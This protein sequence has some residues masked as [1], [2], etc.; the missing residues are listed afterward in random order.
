MSKRC[1]LVTGSFFESIPA[2]HDIYLMKH[3][4]HNWSDEQAT[5]LLRCCLQGANLIEANLEGA[6]LTGANLNGANLTQAFVTNASLNCANL[7]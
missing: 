1:D 3:I 4:L 6:D 7:N 5:E 2:G